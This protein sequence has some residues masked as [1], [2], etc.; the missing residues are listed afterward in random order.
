MPE[1][2]Q[3]KRMPAVPRQIREINPEKDVR[4]R[5]LGKIIDKSDATI[6]IDDGSATAEVVLDTDANVSTD[7]MIRV[8][9]RVIPLEDGMEL[10]A[11]IIQNM[12]ALDMD[13]YK[14]VFSK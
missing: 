8:F 9:A 1:P 4:V 2:F 6:V 5:L 13:L 10:R 14:K 7:D 11:E 3:Y 12:N